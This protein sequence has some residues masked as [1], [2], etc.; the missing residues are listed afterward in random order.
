MTAISLAEFYIARSGFF[1][2]TNYLEGQLDTLLH[3]NSTESTLY[4]NYEFQ[5]QL[6]W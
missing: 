6:H 5:L 2:H 3:M 4:K 1:K